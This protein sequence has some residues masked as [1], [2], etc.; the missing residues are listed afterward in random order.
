MQEAEEASRRAIADIATGNRDRLAWLASA[1][2]S[3]L[4]TRPAAKTLMLATRRQAHIIQVVIGGET[5]E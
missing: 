1:C 3:A 2:G 4:S 5:T